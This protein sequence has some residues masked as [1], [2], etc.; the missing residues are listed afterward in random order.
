MSNTAL[1]VKISEVNWR[2]QEYGKKMD[3]R[4]EKVFGYM[5]EHERFLIVDDEQIYHNGAS[6]KDTG[7][8]CSVI[9]MLED[10]RIETDI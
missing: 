1:F 3:E 9:N 7:K 4:F 5:A 2:Q 10:K 6:L 8:K